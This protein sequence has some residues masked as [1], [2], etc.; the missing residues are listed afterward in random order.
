ML[1][2]P[3]KMGMSLLKVFAME[4]MAIGVT[5]VLFYYFSQHS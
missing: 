3:D 5:G 2:D 4:F 1:I